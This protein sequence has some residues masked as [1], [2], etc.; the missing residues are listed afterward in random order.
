[1]RVRADKIAEQRKKDKEKRDRELEERVRT[2]ACDFGTAS[3]R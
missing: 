2:R 1:V 3:R